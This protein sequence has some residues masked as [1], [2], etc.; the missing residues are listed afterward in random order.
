MLSWAAT[1]IM[2][3][4]PSSARAKLNLSAFRSIYNPEFKDTPPRILCC[5]GN[6]GDQLVTSAVQK[7]LRTVRLIQ[8]SGVAFALI[9]ADVSFVTWSFD[10]VTTV[11][12]HRKNVQKIPK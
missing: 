1:L 10:V 7:Q 4:D 12:D 11:Q 6:S 9:L 8:A 3:Y 2:F 5:V